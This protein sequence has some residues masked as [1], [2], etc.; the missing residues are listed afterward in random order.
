MTGPNIRVDPDSLEAAGKVARRQYQHINEIQ[1]YI[2]STCH[3]FQAFTGVMDLFQG[4]YENALQSVSD[5]LDKA[6]DVSTKTERSFNV[7]ADDFRETDRQAYEKAKRHA[8]AISGEG[9][10]FPPYRPAGSGDTDP[11]GP[12]LDPLKPPKDEKSWDV[13]GWVT[14]PTVRD[15]A[16][17]KHD[18]EYVQD[19]YDAANGAGNIGTNGILS[20]GSE[21]KPPAWLD[22]V[23]A[24]KE[25]IKDHTDFGTSV[26]DRME[27]HDR[28][29]VSENRSNA[30]DSAYHHA[31]RDALNDGS[32]PDEARAAGREAGREASQDSA[33]ATRSEHTAR[34]RVTGTLGDAKGVVDEARNAVSNV[35]SAVDHVHHTV[36][37]IEDANRYD[38]YNNSARNDS[39]D[40]WADDKSGEDWAKE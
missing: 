4:T 33:D 19:V 7:T 25:W 8:I 39:T 21:I 27:A 28:A 32:S 18:P 34:D 1:S 10:D 31:Q 13:P 36:D 14:V 17:L 5:G 24:G 35:K 30:Y 37:N 22:P 12:S 38:D 20:H 40:D 15:L 9:V 2:S 3:Q 29:E 11:G 16:G 26:D 6:L 23:G